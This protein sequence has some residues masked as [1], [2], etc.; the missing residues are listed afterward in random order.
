M[1][2]AGV[3]RPLFC[4]MKWPMPNRRLSA[5][6]LSE[7]VADPRR[8]LTDPRYWYEGLCCRWLEHVEQQLH[9]DP[10]H[11]RPLAILGVRLALRVG[12]R[13]EKLRIRNRC[14]LAAAHAVLGSAHRAAG[15]LDRAERALAKATELARGCDDPDARSDV[16]M[17]L[18]V[19]RAYQ[20]QRPDGS[21]E[22]AAL[23]AAF[24][25]A[26]TA[27]RE[28]R[29]A[30][31]KARAL[32]ARAFLHGLS[33][34]FTAGEHD[35]RRALELIDP[36]IRPLDHAAITSMLVWMLSSGSKTDREEAVLF[37]QRLRLDLPAR[38]PAIS[39]RFLWAQALLQL[40]NRRHQARAQRLLDR[41]RR[42]FLRL[43]MSAEAV[44]TTADLARIDPA[45][46]VYRLCADLLAILEPGPVR[47]LVLGLQ[48]ARLPERANLADKL[49]A[50]IQGPGL[51][52]VAVWPAQ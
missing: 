31:A 9:A 15:D 23:A 27:L 50:A 33:G 11:A 10:P 4:D 18:S 13:R 22:P 38:L 52:P 40:P 17:R 51:L 14:L 21:F 49:R 47:E 37:L 1:K 16:A 44:A 46:A 30:T 43:G 36:K 29:T 24:E 39:A 3:C 12:H 5:S 28:A 34:S 6:Q 2:G 41:S 48:R 35:A 7:M 45:G 32:N 19:L 26:E 25:P 42:T 8:A 20:A